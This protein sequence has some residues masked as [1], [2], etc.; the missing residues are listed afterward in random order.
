M[1]K[2]MKEFEHM[3]E[4]ANAHV[5]TGSVKQVPKKEGSMLGHFPS[6][7]MLIAGQ[8]IKPV[9]PGNKNNLLVK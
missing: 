8:P 9:D 4:Q 3:Q 7:N 6:S 2:I 5:H 1:T